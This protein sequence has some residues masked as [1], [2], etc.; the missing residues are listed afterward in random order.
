M[1]KFT[2][3]IAVLAVLVGIG[4]LVLFY[5]ASVVSLCSCAYELSI[6]VYD[7]R[8]ADIEE[9]TCEAFGII[10]DAEFQHYVRRP[11]KPFY[12]VSAPHFRGEP[13]IVTIPYGDRV[14]P[15]G[16]SRPTYPFTKLVIVA[17]YKDGRRSGKLVDIPKP[18]EAQSIVVS[19]Q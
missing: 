5:D 14:S 16:R 12:G 1:R 15:L 17:Q 7:D 10:D 18:S 6:V 13:V 3:L 2:P 9:L 11:W 4:G 19:L 8:I